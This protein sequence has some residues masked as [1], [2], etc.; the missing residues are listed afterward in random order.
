[1]TSG[2][3]RRHH[4]QP[5]VLLRQFADANKKIAVVEKATGATKIRNV[6]S[7]SVIKDAN[8]L[9]VVGGF[10]F[11]LEHSLSKIENFYPNIIRSLDNSALRRRR[12]FHFGSCCHANGA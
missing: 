1:M 3:P 11:S 12:C 4:I 2:S 6:R 8:K 10:D 7:V 5:Q 9:S